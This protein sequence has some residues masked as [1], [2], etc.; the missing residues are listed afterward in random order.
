MM[1]AGMAASEVLARAVKKQ[2]DVEE[3]M[4][5]T[6]QDQYAHT[7]TVEDDFWV[8]SKASGFGGRSRGKWQDLA[9]LGILVQGGGSSFDVNPDAEALHDAVMRLDVIGRG[10]VITHGVA[11]TR[12]DWMPND[13]PR[14]VMRP[15]ANGK[16][17][18]EYW[19]AART[20]PA[21]CLLCY[22]PDPEHVKFMRKV[23]VTWWDALACLIDEN[24][25]LDA[26]ELTGPAILREPWK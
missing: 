14:L 16:P 17:K 15:R 10:L 6:Y 5:W 3:M 7:I 23:Y 12:P 25:Y 13:D 19:D 18:M 9:D 21:Y 4:R 2:V 1:M 11:G 22:D 24:Q 8:I 26:H 20:R